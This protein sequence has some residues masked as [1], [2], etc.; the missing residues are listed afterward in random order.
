MQKSDFY[1]LTIG[2]KVWFK[3]EEKEIDYLQDVDGRL[4]LS[5]YKQ[6]PTY[7]F[8]DIMHELEFEK[9]ECK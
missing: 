6:V 5:F 9:P 1:K 7:Y 4:S 3:G 8:T 2:M